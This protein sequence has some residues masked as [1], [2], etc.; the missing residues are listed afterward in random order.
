MHEEE[1]GLTIVEIGM[2]SDIEIIIYFELFLG[3][4]IMTDIEIEITSIVLYYEFN[5]VRDNVYIFSIFELYCI[6]C[7][8]FI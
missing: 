5:I 1:E 3:C 4:C 8:L 6:Y 2:F 7:E